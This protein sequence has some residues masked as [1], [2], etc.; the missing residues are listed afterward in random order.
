MCIRDR[1]SGK[2]DSAKVGE[3]PE[4]LHQD[5]RFRGVTRVRR[6]AGVSFVNVLAD[7]NFYITREEIYHAYCIASYRVAARVCFIPA[8]ISVNARVVSRFVFQTCSAERT[9][10]HS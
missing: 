2:Q 4:H 7:C 6:A 1:R 10:V 5:A 8:H 3:H 9:L